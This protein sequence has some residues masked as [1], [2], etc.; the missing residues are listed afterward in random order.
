[1]QWKHITQRQHPA[2]IVSAGSEPWK[3]I[4]DMSTKH[5]VHLAGN[6]REGNQLEIHI[7]SLLSSP[8]PIGLTHSQKTGG[9]EG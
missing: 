4:G 3:T 6:R 2:K 1:M 5:F 8:L 9:R 7:S